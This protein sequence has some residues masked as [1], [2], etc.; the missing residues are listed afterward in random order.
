M[1]TLKSLVDE[2]TKIK[3]ELVTC[4]TN[5]KNNLV[6]K[7][8]ECGSKEKMST[9]IG[10]VGDVKVIPNV[11][12]GDSTVIFGT[13]ERIGS[14]S[15]TPGYWNYDLIKFYVNGSVRLNFD[16]YT[17]KRYGKFKFI[18]TSNSGV[19]KHESQVFEGVS[20]QTTL[21][22]YDIDNIEN[23]D[24]LSLDVTGM[25][26]SYSSSLNNLKISCDGI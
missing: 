19:V 4:Y 8:V 14:T 10:K 9:L 13:I 26:S 24:V 6:A 15:S 16:I 11:I 1:T 18:L 25:N 17:S 2:T 20:G 12:A 3:D 5:L 7:G 23:G 21:Y 22:T